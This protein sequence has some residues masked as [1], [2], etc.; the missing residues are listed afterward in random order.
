MEH[1]GG[2]QTR[3]VAGS[4]ACEDTLCARRRDLDPAHRILV[5]L[6]GEGGRGENR[7]DDEGDG[8]GDQR[9]ADGN[10]SNTSSG[11]EHLLIPLHLVM[12]TVELTE[13]ATWF[14][15]T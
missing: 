6:G 1:V 7:S 12:R 8:R 2:P 4:R 13:P 5:L 10:H 11:G 3:Q 14:P 9:F 15:P